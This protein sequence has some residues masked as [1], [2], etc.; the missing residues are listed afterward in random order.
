MDLH[1]KMLEEKC[2]PLKTQE[3]KKTICILMKQG[4]LTTGK[5]CNEF[6]T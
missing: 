6:K 4:F 2:K 3:E 5:E 1:Q